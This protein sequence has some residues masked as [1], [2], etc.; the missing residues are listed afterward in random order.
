MSTLAEIE[1]AAA[2]LNLE[3]QQ[4]LLARLAAKVRAHVT[5]P[6][7]QPRI[8]GLHRG[9]VWMSDDF[10]DPLPDEFWLGKDSENSLKQPE[11]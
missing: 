10:N 1:I 7:N 5:L 11:P 3:E 4:V 6:A 2:S 9:L 8:P